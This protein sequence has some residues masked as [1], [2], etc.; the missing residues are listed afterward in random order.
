MPGPKQN[1]NTYFLRVHDNTNIDIITIEVDIAK[2]V[3]L[4]HR[5]LE[6][7]ISNNMNNLDRTAE[8]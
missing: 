7:R 3:S 8:I 1:P 5:V 2:S 4:L 6:S